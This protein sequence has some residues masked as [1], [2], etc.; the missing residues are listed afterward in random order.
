MKRKIK[1]TDC[2]KPAVCWWP[3][4][5]PDIQSFPFCRNCVEERKHSLMLRLLKIDEEKE[6]KN[7]YKGRG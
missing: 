5:D 4:C 6:K 3:A 7:G 1:C 2:N